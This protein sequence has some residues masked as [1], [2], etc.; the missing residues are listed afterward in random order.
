MSHEKKETSELRLGLQACLEPG[1][2]FERQWSTGVKATSPEEFDQFTDQLARSLLETFTPE[3]IATIAAQHIIAMDELKCLQAEQEAVQEAVIQDLTEKARMAWLAGTQRA[4]DR[5]KKQ[6]T[7]KRMAGGLDERNKRASFI[8]E[9]IERH[10][11]EIWAADTDQ[12]FR[13]TEM[14]SLVKNAVEQDHPGEAP[15]L[16]RIKVLIRPVAPDYARK[17]GAPKGKR[18]R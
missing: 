14:A 3:H 11:R 12:E 13:V 16:D 7:T 9:E 15:D 4:L 6:A 17:G 8:N 18:M 1:F 10:A 5:T 2:T